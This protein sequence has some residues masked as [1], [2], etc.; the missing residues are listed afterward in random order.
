[1][2][3]LHL[4]EQ[5][6]FMDEEEFKQHIE[7]K[8]PAI[9]EYL[10]GDIL[11]VPIPDSWLISSIIDFQKYCQKIFPAEIEII[12]MPSLQFAQILRK[13]NKNDKS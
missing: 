13:A 5:G 8:F 10:P 4:V 2:I 6:K 1:M 7:L 12:C 3:Q 11:L 9:L